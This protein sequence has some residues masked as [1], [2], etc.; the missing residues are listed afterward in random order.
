MTNSSW[1]K[2]IRKTKLSKV[3]T[4]VDNLCYIL[5]NNPTLNVTVRKNEFTERIEAVEGLPFKSVTKVWSDQNQALLLRYLAK[6]Y[7]ISRCKDELVNAIEAVSSE[8]SY[9]PVREYLDA[10]PKCDGIRRIPTM[11]VDYLGVEDTTYCRTVSERWMVSAV[12]RIYEPGFKA[13]S[14]LLISGRQGIGKSSFFA[15]LAVKPEWYT[16]NV[17]LSMDSK[18]SVELLRGRWIIE[19]SE[20]ATL[21]RSEVEAS[22]P[23]SPGRATSTAQH[24]GDLSLLLTG[25]ASSARPQTRTLSSEMRPAIEDSGVWKRRT[26]RRSRYGIPSPMRWISSGRRRRPSIRFTRTKEAGSTARASKLW[27]RR[28]LIV[29][30]R[31]ILGRV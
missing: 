18:E 17:G 13:D 29:S 6:E 23:S 7:G 12:A 4:D 16:D 20:L 22:R 27:S 1:K 24:M 9:H 26:N 21:K 2:K 30:K 3:E 15:K 28:K 8:R 11:L 14:L 5:E 31:L 10:L 25:S 19:I